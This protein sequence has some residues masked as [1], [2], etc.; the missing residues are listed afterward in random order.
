MDSTECDLSDGP[1]PLFPYY[2][3]YPYRIVSLT[4]TD[5]EGS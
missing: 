3:L 2:L 5:V 4:H 1:Q